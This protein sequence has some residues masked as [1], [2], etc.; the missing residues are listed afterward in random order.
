MLKISKKL[1]NIEK[2]IKKIEVEP[3]STQ[4]HKVIDLEKRKENN[5]VYIKQLIQ[6]EIYYTPEQ[7]LDLNAQ[8]IKYEHNQVFHKSNPNFDKTIFQQKFKERITFNK[9]PKIFNDKIIKLQY[10]IPQSLYDKINEIIKIEYFNEYNSRDNRIRRKYLSKLEQALYLV[11]AIYNFNQ[12]KNEQ[13]NSIIKK[14]QKNN[15]PINF[16][17]INKIKQKYDLEYRL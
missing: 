12:Q 9:L 2:I 1:K 11:L 8:R 13:I 10:A 17:Y 7:A 14:Y 5:D 15:L 16:N 4:Y 3:K 6:D